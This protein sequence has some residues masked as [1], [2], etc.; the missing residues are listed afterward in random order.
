MSIVLTVIIALLSFLGTFC[1]RADSSPV[2]F[3]AVICLFIQVFLIVCVM[4]REQGAKKAIP[5][6]V[7]IAAW[8]IAFIVFPAKE[9]IPLAKDILGFIKTAIY[10]LIAIPVTIFIAR[11]FF[12][13]GGQDT[14]SGEKDDASSQTTFG[15]WMPNQ[16]IDDQN[17]YWV[18]DY[19]GP[20]IA[21]Y[22]CNSTGQ[23]VE[24]YE[25]S[26]QYYGGSEIRGSDGRTWH[27]N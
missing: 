11:I 10:W 1:H 3:L 9:D 20:N 27:F 17:N 14:A 13:G 5:I 6:P 8:I 21:R 4:L 25:G 15:E 19:A 2:Q 22:H 24:L 18:K 16:L 23:S 7:A 12:G 26:T